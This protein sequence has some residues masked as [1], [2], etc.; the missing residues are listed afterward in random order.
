MTPK[1]LYIFKQANKRENQQ[2]FI[3]FEFKSFKRG[4]GTG[5]VQAADGHGKTQLGTCIGIPQRHN[6]E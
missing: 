4:K 1:A 3:G 6:T 5:K 2:I